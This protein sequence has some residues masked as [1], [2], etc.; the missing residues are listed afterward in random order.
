MKPARLNSLL[1]AALLALL[2]TLA[3]A[4][5]VDLFCAQ[6]GTS[7]CVPPARLADLGVRHDRLAQVIHALRGGGLRGG[8][9]SLSAANGAGEF[10]R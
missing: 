8:G 4:A 2:A 9:Q 1:A 3:A 5:R 10:M 7:P 6:A